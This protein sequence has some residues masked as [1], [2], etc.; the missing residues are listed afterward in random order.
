VI[1]SYDHQYFDLK[2]HTLVL[3]SDANAVALAQRKGVLLPPPLPKD[4]QVGRAVGGSRC[5]VYAPSSGAVVA[6]WS[7]AAGPDHEP[8]QFVSYWLCPDPNTGSTVGCRIWTPL[9]P[10]SNF[11]TI[12][13]TVVAGGDIYVVGRSSPA[14]AATHDEL[15]RFD[16]SSTGQWTDCAP[17]P[18]LMHPQPLLFGSHF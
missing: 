7:H 4:A 5:T 11:L 9:P 10:V 1:N 12:T 16:A 8:A 3:E 13:T 2:T 18:V 6:C 17:L 15:K 14:A